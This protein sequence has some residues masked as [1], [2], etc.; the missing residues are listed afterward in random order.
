MKG[1]LRKLKSD[2][3]IAYPLCIN[4]LSLIRP[5]TDCYWQ[6][7]RQSFFQSPKYLL[8]VG[9][10]L[11]SLEILSTHL[12]SLLA[13]DQNSGRDQAGI[14]IAV[15]KF[16]LFLLLLISKIGNKDT[17]SFP[18]SFWLALD[19]TPQLAQSVIWW[20]QQNVLWSKILILRV[21]IYQWLLFPDQWFS[22]RD[23]VPSEDIWQRLELFWLS[24]LGDIMGICC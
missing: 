18:L 24:W 8:L 16:S 1:H 6:F 13:L 5:C 12:T 10:A 3:P 9:K 19:K 14:Q 17:S 4:K 23:N 11:V 7:V 21:R 15:C 2:L 20:G 22:A